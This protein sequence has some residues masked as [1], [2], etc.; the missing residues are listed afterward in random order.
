MV[1][2]IDFMDN[3]CQY[4]TNKNGRDLFYEECKYPKK[5]KDGSPNDMYLEEL[6]VKVDQRKVE[7]D[8]L[9]KELLSPKFVKKMGF[10]EEVRMGYDKMFIAGQGLGGWTSIY[11]AC[12]D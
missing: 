7:V 2:S 8:A 1:A 11:A 10:G 6:K 9:A 5:N 12:G 3:T 4:T